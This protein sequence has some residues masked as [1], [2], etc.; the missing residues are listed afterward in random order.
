MLRFFVSETFCGPERPLN[1]TNSGF[2]SVR[3]SRGSATDVN[4]IDTK[5]PVFVNLGMNI[6]PVGA[7]HSE[8]QAPC[9]NINT[10]VSPKGGNNHS[11][12]PYRTSKL[13]NVQGVLKVRNT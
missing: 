1:R 5:L 9:L 4:I 6:M 11:A 3:L 10:D 2:L 13:C 12:I 8:Y 7:T